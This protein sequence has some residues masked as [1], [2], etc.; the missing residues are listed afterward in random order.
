MKVKKMS[1]P[2]DLSKKLLQWMKGC[3]REPLLTNPYPSMR[4]LTIPES[5]KNL[6]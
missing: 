1:I 2:S 3:D 5:K 4:V 6:L